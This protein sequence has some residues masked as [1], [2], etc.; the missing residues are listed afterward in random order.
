M[1]SGL[2]ADVVDADQVS[3][4]L[5]GPG[6]PLLR[7]IADAWGHDLIREDGSL[8]RAALAGRVFGRPEE[9]ARL[10][11]LT[12]PPIM[13]EMRR[14]IETSDAEVAVLMAPLLLEAGGDAD[15]DE[16]WVVA[17]DPARRV[18]RVM[19]R[20]AATETDALRRIAAQLDEEERLR[21]ADVVIRN[22]GSVEAVRAQVESA[23]RDARR[24]MDRGNGR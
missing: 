7:E 17:A 15:V 2:G 20:D 19:E 5:V 4:D 23:L 10:N 12:H 6:A 13:A 3:R 18:R 16:I 11:A 22:E 21:R 14:R 8:D 9:V 1:L 24:R